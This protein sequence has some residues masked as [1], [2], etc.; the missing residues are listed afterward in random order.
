MGRV[1]RILPHPA[2][3]LLLR[4]VRCFFGQFCYMTERLSTWIQG[5]LIVAL[6]TVLQG[7]SGNKLSYV[8][9]WECSTGNGRFVEIKRND[10]SFL[11]TDN[12]GTYPAS[13][14][15]D[16]RLVVHASGLAGDV[17][18]VI[19]RSTGEL[20]CPG[21]CGCDRFKRVK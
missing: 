5:L 7:C 11:W 20:V 8:G 21:V 14:N 16:G 17:S 1:G 18:V 6:I 19:D 13:L 2:G 9:R 12:E 15:P 4:R 3:T 10:S